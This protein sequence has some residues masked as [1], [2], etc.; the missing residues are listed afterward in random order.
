MSNPPDASSLS[1]TEPTTPFHPA[2]AFSPPHSEPTVT[3]LMPT[4]PPYAASSHILESM[5]YELNVIAETKRRDGRGEPSD[6]PSPAL[7][8]RSR[9][10]HRLPMYL[11][12]YV[13]QAIES[14]TPGPSLLLSLIHI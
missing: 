2:D 13:C 5:A 9:D 14:D 11:R 1:H 7:P 8:S 12:D 3:T 4:N 6:S 10:D